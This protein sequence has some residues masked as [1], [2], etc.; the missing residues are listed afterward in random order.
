MINFVS[1]RDGSQTLNLCVIPELH[2]AVI[3]FSCAQSSEKIPM[4]VRLDERVLAKRT[5]ERHTSFE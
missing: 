1:K 2:R 3:V 5:I 4:I